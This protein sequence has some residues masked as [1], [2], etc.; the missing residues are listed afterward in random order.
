MIIK[1]ASI[2]NHLNTPAVSVV[3]Y[4]FQVPPANII[5]F[6][7]CKSLIALCLLNL[8]AIPSIQKEFK[9]LV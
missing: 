7:D 5:T 3:K 2:S 4:G 6:P 8:S 1:S 9:I